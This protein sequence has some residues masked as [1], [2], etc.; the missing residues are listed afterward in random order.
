MCWPMGFNHIFCSRC[1][2]RSPVGRALVARGQIFTGWATLAR[3]CG[4]S[5]AALDL[6][7]VVDIELEPD[8]GYWDPISCV[9]SG[10]LGV[11]VWLVWRCRCGR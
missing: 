1:V 9:G 7:V 5:A 11:C 10:F 8:D 4:P 3:C 6:N 2:C